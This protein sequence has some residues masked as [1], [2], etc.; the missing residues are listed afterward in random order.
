MKFL[1][2]ISTAVC[3]LSSCMNFKQ[4]ELIGTWTSEQL[5]FSFHEDKT[6][7]FRMGVLKDS[8]KYRPFG[9]SIEI[10]GSNNKVVTRLSVVS[11]E[12]NELVL[13]LPRFESR[14]YTLTRS[15]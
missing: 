7:E 6:L 4:E 15:E 1:F 3:L 12:G 9:N 13:D 14:K 11:L 2:V 5:D 10:I 8:G